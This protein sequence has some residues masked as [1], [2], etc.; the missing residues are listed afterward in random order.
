MSRTSGGSR[1]NARI[2]TSLPAQIAP[3]DVDGGGSHLHRQRA[4]C[5]GLS[6]SGARVL[7]SRPVSPGTEVRIELTLARGQ[8]VSLAGRVAWSKVTTAPSALCSLP[9]ALEESSLGLEF[10]E[11]TSARAM[12]AIADFLS[13][14]RLRRRQRIER[15]VPQLRPGIHRH[16]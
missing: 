11:P 5:V 10:S 9:Q 15:I 8:R 13:R 2:R 12:V 4:I 16:A 14:E 6:R 7:T 1:H 3:I